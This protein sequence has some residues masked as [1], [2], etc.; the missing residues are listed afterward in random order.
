MIRTIT[1]YVCEWAY[2]IISL[3]L[4]V[5]IKFFDKLN[6]V[7]IQEYIINKYT[8]SL[9]KFAKFLAGIK[10]KVYGLENVPE[11]GA[12]LFVSNHQSH[13]DSVVI[14]SCIKK[15]KGFIATIEAKEIP[16]LNIWMKYIKC[17]FMD[18][19]NIR[20]SLDCINKGV[21]ILRQGHSL[22]IYPEGKIVEDGTIGKF[23]RGSLQLAIRAGVPIVPL[24]IKGTN[25]ISDKKISRIKP[26]KVECIIS[27][28]ILTADITR[29]DEKEIFEYVRDVINSNLL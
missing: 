21:D 1:W 9:M 27:K 17:V 8:T 4:I 16:I 14:H 24:T 7:D 29:K 3:P 12:V 20:Q 13:F 5:L 11:T 22:V 10:V 28:P 15:P 18:R 23:K 25:K 26:S 6:K 2:L 19:S